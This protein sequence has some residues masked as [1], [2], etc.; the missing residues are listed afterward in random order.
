MPS[1]T[2]SITPRISLVPEGYFLAQIGEYQQAPSGNPAVIVLHDE[3]DTVF[4]DQWQLALYA[5]NFGMLKNNVAALMGSAKALMNKTGIDNPEEP[6]ENIISGATVPGLPHP[7]LDKLRTFAR[8]TH[9]VR[10]YDS[11]YYQVWTM[12]GARPPLMKPGRIPP[13]S[14]EDIDAGLVRASD[15][16]YS[17]QFTTWAFMACN[18]FRTLP[19]NQTSISP[20]AGGIT[21]P[22]TPA[23]DEIYTWF[24]LT[25]HHTA[26]VLSPKSL[27]TRVDRYQNP[28]RRQ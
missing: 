12:D 2:I 18:N 20:F 1:L 13:R 11:T 21:Y 26:P 7:W 10:D 16:V 5:W 17:P 3:A 4:E 23:P 25:S 27:W 9:A 28:Y 22:W 19:G 24:P 6:R 15:Y 8:A 14:V